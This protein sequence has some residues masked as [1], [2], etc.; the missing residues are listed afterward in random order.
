MI[1]DLISLANVRGDKACILSIDQQKAFDRVS[2]EWMFKVLK[3]CNVGDYFLKWVKILNTGAS[4]KILLNKVL[5]TKYE[6]LR[7]VRQG[8]VLSPIIYILS[9]EPLLEKIR[10]DTSITGLHIPNKGFQKLLAFADDTN[11]FVNNNI[12]INKIISI[13]THFG[14]ASGSLININKTKLMAIGEGLDFN[15]DIL[16]DIVQEMKLL[17]IFYINAINQTHERNWNHLITHIESKINKIYYKQA[18]IFGRAILVNTFI[19]PKLIYPAMTIDPPEN[20]IKSFKKLVRAFIFKGTLPCI[21]HNTIVQLK[22]D[23]GINLHDIE[24]KIKSFRLKFLYKVLENPDSYPLAVYFLSN[25]LHDLVDQNLNEA[26]NGCLPHFYESIKNN[27]T[28]LDTIF[29]NSNSALVYYNIIQSKK[30]PLNDQVK[31]ATNETDLTIIFEALHKNK[32]TTPT[33]KQILYRILFGITPTSEGLAKRHKRVFF[34]KFCSREQETESHIFYSCQSLETIKLNLIRLLRQPHNTFIDLYNSVFLD[35]LPDDG[36]KDLYF[37]KQA[38]LAIYRESVWLARNQATHKNY[39]FSKDQ[40]NNIFQNKIRSFFKRVKENET[41]KL[42][43]I[44]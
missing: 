7:G 8:D 34:C 41:I 31:R 30:Q 17:G 37:I 22:E 27:Y 24:S 23:G 20:I 21:R 16:I 29:H 33:Q 39:I 43:N 14:K 32:Y 12:S 18:S 28:D 15:A 36:N 6:L 3:Q 10:Q 1:R 35:I 42:F 4:S 11:F 5:T 19:E 44:I 2:H 9:L 40:I 13:F 26:Y 38:F 25:T